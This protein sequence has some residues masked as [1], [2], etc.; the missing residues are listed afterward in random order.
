MMIEQP[1]LYCS[2]CGGLIPS[3]EELIANWD[4]ECKEARNSQK[5]EPPRQKWKNGLLSCEACAVESSKGMKVDRR[6]WLA[7]NPVQ[8][9]ERIDV[10]LIF[11]DLPT[12]L[13]NESLSGVCYDWGRMGR[14]IKYPIVDGKKLCGTCLE[15]L[16]IER[17][18]KARNYFQSYCIECRK[19][20]AKQ[21][22]S[23]AEVK[24][25]QL[26]YS[27]GYRSVEENRARLNAATRR[28]RKKPEF[29][30]KRNSVRREWCSREKQ[31]A[32]NYKGGCCVC[33]G[34]SKCLAALDFHHRN[35]LE[36]EGYGTGALKSH[37][38]F[39]RNMPELDKCELV[40]VRCHREIHAGYREL[41]L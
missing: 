24:A 27:R 12:R 9:Q 35:P 6:R 1:P 38:S 40:C 37:W 36:K 10:P 29:R 4:A 41:P 31:K 8:E 17:F 11:I 39:E 16:P 5:D 18:T 23:R 30:G 34:Y 22:R 32:V 14:L 33:C 15:M 7:N 26:D 20:W 28:S 25:K 19:T 3:N 21:Y 13:R 2:A